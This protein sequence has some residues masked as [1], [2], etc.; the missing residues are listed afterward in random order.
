MSAANLSLSL[1]LFLL[2]LQEI[3][4]VLWVGLLGM[5]RCASC[6]SFGCSSSC[7][8]FTLPEHHRDLESKLQTWSAMKFPGALKSIRAVW[9]RVQDRGNP[10]LGALVRE[11]PKTLDC[12]YEFHCNAEVTFCTPTV[13]V[14]KDESWQCVS[15]NR[16]ESLTNHMMTCGEDAGAVSCSQA[17]GLRLRRLGVETALQLRWRQMKLASGG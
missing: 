9:S 6:D 12:N 16:I 7:E 5:F 14:I 10:T 11:I 4:Y 1:S 15:W 8:D 17:R 3:G 2:L 13:S